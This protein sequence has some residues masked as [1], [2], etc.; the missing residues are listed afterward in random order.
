MAA[1]F[2]ICAILAV[3]GAL[4]MVFSK[5]AVHSALCVAL[6]MLNL[7]VLYATLDA[8]FLSMVQ[9]IVY[10]GAVMM[11]FLF[12]LMIVGVDSSDSLKET[13]KGQRVPAI[14][15]GL[16]FGI[17]LVG[18]LGNVV[19]YDLGLDAANAR[20]GS[21]MQGIANLVFVDDIFAFEFTSALLITAAIGAMVLAHREHHTPKPTQRELSEARFKSGKH[22]GSLPSPGVYARHNAVDTPALLPDG[23][24]SELSVPKP[25]AARGAL[26]AVVVADHSEV[27]ALSRGEAV[28]TAQDGMEG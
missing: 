27:A 9:V 5:K 4:G 26:K 7:A 13:I 15:G 16:A 17:M 10:T 2:W 24:M 11:L 1:T 19:T 20:A 28:I 21:N 14:L 8:P 3:L 18:M 25:L 23:T 22:P 12:V 6:T